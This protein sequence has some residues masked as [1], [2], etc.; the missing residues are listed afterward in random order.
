MLCRSGRRRQASIHIAP[1]EGCFGHQQHFL[2]EE[3]A[4]TCLGGPVVQWECNEG[5]LKMM[6]AYRDTYRYSCNDI[7]EDVSYLLLTV[8]ILW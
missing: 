4:G 7:L 2:H 5:G 6:V 8:K 1:P 3:G